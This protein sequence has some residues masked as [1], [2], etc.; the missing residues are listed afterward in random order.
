MECLRLILEASA[1]G[2]V[3]AMD[4]Q[5]QTPLHLAAAAGH[6][7]A[8]QA[9][10]YRGASAKTVDAQARDALYLA[11][12]NGHADVVRQLVAA[13]ADVRCAAQHGWTP[14]HAAVQ[15]GHTDVVRVLVVNHARLDAALQESGKT[16]LH[17]AVAASTVNT[18]MLQVLLT[19]GASLFFFL[20]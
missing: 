19:V 4:H 13:G 15:G 6:T 8:K 12:L 10:L 7:D 11:A 5:A 17:L 16:P 2:L 18:D 1:A 20:E 14:L 9:L 3:Y